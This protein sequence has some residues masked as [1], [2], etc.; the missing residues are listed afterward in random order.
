VLPLLKV[1]H[2]VLL[3][4]SVAPKKPPRNLLMMKGRF[5]GQRQAMMVL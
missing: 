1:S 4:S 2:G 3:P 5:G